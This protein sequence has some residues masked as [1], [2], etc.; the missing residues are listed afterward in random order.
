MMPRS[1]AQSDFVIATEPV[2]V[3]LPDVARAVEL[4][5]MKVRTQEAGEV[6]TRWVMRLVLFTFLLLGLIMWLGHIPSGG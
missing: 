5:M 2:P 3:E 4:P 1:Q 6:A